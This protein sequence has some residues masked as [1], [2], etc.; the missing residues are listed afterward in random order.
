[1]HIKKLGSSAGLVVK[2]LNTS[3]CIPFPI[4][5]RKPNV[6]ILGFYITQ[7]QI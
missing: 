5:G 4:H 6:F 1:M 2:N 7:I 3:I